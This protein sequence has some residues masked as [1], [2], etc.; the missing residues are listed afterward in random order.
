MRFTSRLSSGLPGVMRVPTCRPEQTGTRS[1]IQTALL[2]A[3]TVTH[4]TL[5]V[6]DAYQDFLLGDFL[7]SRE[8]LRA[9]RVLTSRRA[10]VAIQ[11]RMRSTSGSWSFLP[12]IG[13]APVAILITSKLFPLNPVRSPALTLHP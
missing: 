3:L 8:L 1:Q 9:V 12:P 7:G 6:E 10:P 4:Q 5:D 13:I 11:R 2:L